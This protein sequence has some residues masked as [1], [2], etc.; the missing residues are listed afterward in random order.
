MLGTRG[1]KQ[2]KLK[3]EPEGFHDRGRLECLRVNFLVERVFLV[4]DKHDLFIKDKRDKKA[5][6]AYG[7]MLNPISQTR[8]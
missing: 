5:D 2:H 6:L 1:G 4:Q 7:F 3:R 8:E